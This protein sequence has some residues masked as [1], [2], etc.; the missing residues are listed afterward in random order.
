MTRKSGGLR[1][2]KYEG[3]GN[4]F[5][6]VDGDAQVDAELARH[7]CDRHRGIGADGV[8]IVNASTPSMEVRDRPCAI[9]P[10][11]GTARGTTRAA[12]TLSLLL[13]GR[14]GHGTYPDVWREPER[15]GVSG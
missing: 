2:S 1:F 11:D 9:E 7:L 3:L 8:L 14:A 6:V 10:S 5:I 12:L 13:G 15:G 4:D